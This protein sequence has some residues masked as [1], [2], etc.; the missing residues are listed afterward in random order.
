MNGWQWALVAAVLS[1]TVFGLAN[2]WFPWPVT[3]WERGSWAFIFD[4]CD[5]WV[6]GYYSRDKRTAYLIIVPMFPLRWR[7]P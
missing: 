1:W 4:P 3:L 6:G 5:F 7:L 2:L